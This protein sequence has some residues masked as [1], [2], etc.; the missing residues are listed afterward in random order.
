M[1]KGLDDVSRHVRK[2]SR[3]LGRILRQ[4]FVAQM[5]PSLYVFMQ[6]RFIRQ[7]VAV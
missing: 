3:L 7:S 5:L 2:L 6:E 1:R 4:D